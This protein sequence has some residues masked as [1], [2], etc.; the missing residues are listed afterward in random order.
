MKKIILTLTL[1]VMS[2]TSFGMSYEQAREH[3][4]FL[5]DKMAYEL[6]L[7]EEQYEA[8][9]EVNLDYLMGVQTADEVYSEYWRR[10]NLDLSYILFDWQYTRFCT[11]EY[12]YRPL[13]WYDGFW[14]FR[15]FAHYPNR[16]FFYFGRPGCYITY[17]GGHSWHMN[18]GRSWYHGHSFTHHEY[19]MRGGWDRGG[20]RNM[21]NGWRS[22]DGRHRGISTSQHST[23]HR[24]TGYRGNRTTT[25]RNNGESNRY[26][27]GSNRGNREGNSTYRDNGSN[28]G[29]RTSRGEGYRRSSTRETVGTTPSSNGSGYSPSHSFSNGNNVQRRLNGEGPRQVSQPARGFGNTSS[30]RIESKDASTMGTSRGIFRSVSPS[31]SSSNSS[32]SYSSGSS[33]TS[34]SFS[35]SSSRSS[36]SGSSRSFS[37]GSA[38]RSVSS[39]HSGSSHGGHFGGGNR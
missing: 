29:N 9:Y 19:G 25:D 23:S 2:L 7:T 18:G 16:T 30:S 22:N 28:R 13:Y 11:I 14:R 38:S 1:A 33:N 36:Y 15:I 6:D 12:F 26:D 20:Y 17:R 37:G 34:R 32:G 21:N 27:N 5:T 24:G 8:A 31:R 35:G 3:A 10:R 39:G 4:L